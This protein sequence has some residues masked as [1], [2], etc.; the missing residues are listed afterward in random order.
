MLCF[1]VVCHKQTIFC[2]EAL[3]SYPPNEC[4]VLTSKTKSALCCTLSACFNTID[5]AFFMQLHSNIILI[6]TGCEKK[7]IVEF[8]HW[9]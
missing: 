3:F 8:V 4:P 9:E 5:E 2:V 6:E 7:E 1:D